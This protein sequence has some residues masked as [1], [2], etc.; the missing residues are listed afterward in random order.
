MIRRPP[1]STL[2]PYTTLFRSVGARGQLL[3]RN[4]E[5]ETEI[6][7][8]LGARVGLPARRGRFVDDGDLSFRPCVHSCP[9]SRGPGSD[10]PFV[11]DLR[12]VEGRIQSQ[13]LSELL[14]GR[15]LE[16]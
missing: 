7:L 2:F 6:I 8:D 15:I 12:A 3:T 16:Q 10:D 11:P 14:Y 1:R 13:A 5:R 4:A 9:Q